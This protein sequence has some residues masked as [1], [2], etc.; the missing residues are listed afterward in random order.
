MTPQLKKYVVAI[1][2]LAL[3]ISV[4]LNL[5]DHF[6]TLPQMQATTNNMRV[7]ALKQW[8]DTME[9]IRYTLE[10]AS[11][12]LDVYEAAYHTR[13]AGE[14]VDIY[15]VGIGYNPET[16]PMYTYDRETLSY[17]LKRSTSDLEYAVLAIY[18]GNQTGVITTQYLDYYVWEK[19]GNIRNSIENIT[20]TMIISANG[21]DPVKQLQEKGNLNIVIDYCKQISE[22]YIEITT[23]MQRPSIAREPITREE[24]I[25]IGTNSELVKEGLAISRSFTIETNYRNSSMV[26]QLKLWNSELYEKVPEGHSVWE[27][28]WWLTYQYPPGGHNVIVIVDAEMATIIHEKKGIAY[29]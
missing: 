10:H 22:T 25:E 28:I 23:Y 20:N 12:N 5:Y 15:G 6:I 18:F 3:I 16:T 24:A 13:L 17:W 4:G 26:E 21:V 29:C 2:V 7:Q 11:T 1:L 14:L 27:V 9:R 8:L 19:I